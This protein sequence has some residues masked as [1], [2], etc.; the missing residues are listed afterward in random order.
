MLNIRKFLEGLRIIPRSSTAIDTKG[1]IEVLDS[2][3]KLRYHNGTSASAVVT[4]SHASQGADRLQNKDLDASS[5]KVVDPTDTTKKVGF[6]VAGATASTTTTLDFNQSAN[7][8]ISFPDAN[9]TL[10]T[11]SSTN[12]LSNKTLE[13]STSWFVDNADNT[14]AIK[15]DAAGSTG[16]STT[17]ASSQ[18]ANRTVTLPDATGTVVLSSGSQV[19]TDKLL[20]DTTTAVVDTGDNTK[21][22]KFDAG[23]TA[24]TSTT[25][26]ASQTADRTVSLPDASTT[27]V[28]TDTTQTLTNKTLTDST[29]FLQDD[30][31]NTKK[32]Q[33]QLSGITTGTTRTLTAPDV[34][35]TIVGTDATQ[36]LTNKTFTDSSTQFQ[37]DG[38]NTKQFR[39]QASGISTATTRTISVPDADITL[40]GTDTTQTLTNKTLTDSTTFLQDESDNSK[41]LQFQ[42]SGITTATTRTLTAP[43]ANTTIVG[44]DATQVITNKDIDGG[45]AANNR[46][47]TIPKDTKTNLDALTRK[48]GTV[49]YA[50]DTDKLYVDD[51]TTLNAVGSASGLSTNFLILDSSFLP[52]KSTNANAEESVGDWLAYAD[53]AAVSP[54]DMTGGSPNTTITRTTTSGEVLNG[55]ASFEITISS[56]ASRQGEGVYVVVNIPKEARGKLVKFTGNFLTSGAILADDI[57]QYAYDITNSLL[58]TPTEVNKVVGEYGN[59]VSYFNIPTNTT[60]IRLGFHIARTSTAALS[61]Y[62]DDMELVVS[63]PSYQTPVSDWVEYTP[64]FTGLGTVTGSSCFYRLV[65]D[66]LQV[67]ARFTVG[68]TT[69]TEARVSFPTG[70]TASSSKLP[71]TLALVGNLLHANAGSINTLAVYA[72][73]SVGYFTFGYRD[74]S[75][76]GFAK[77]NGSSTFVSS[78]VSGFFAEVPLDGVSGNVAVGFGEGAYISSILAAGTRVT[79]TPDVLGEYRT[80][81][82]SGASVITGTDSAPSTGPSAANGM[83][84]YANKNFGTA[85][86]SGEPGRW[87]IFVGKNKVPQLEFYSGTGKTGWVDVRILDV[88]TADIYGLYTAYDPNTG[89]VIIDGIT[90]SS[91][92]TGGRFAGI[93]FTG[94]GASAGAA[95]SCYFDIRVFDRAYVAGTAW[96][97]S[98][99]A[100]YQG[101]G[102]GSTNTTVRRFTS[103][104]S[105]IGQDI[106]Y[107]DSAT[108]GGSF[109]VNKTGWYSI[110]YSDNGSGTGDIGIT[111]NS[112][113]LTTG[114]SSITYAQ[115]KRS[116]A[117]FNGNTASCSWSGYLNAGDIIRAQFGGTMTN[118]A[119]QTIMTVNRI[120]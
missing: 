88:V 61:L 54:V 94:G 45:T 115:G 95:S 93:S 101:N 16:T 68:T 4:E 27:L 70:F 2:S 79:S 9:G 36:V 56:G 103:Q 43:D 20:D 107:A 92:N 17:I 116:N 23:G 33:F 65:G 8:T 112:T 76:A 106:T 51:G 83:L 49:V 110:A 52:N 118:S 10:I 81:H 53:A 6:D 86:T 32:L 48:E 1:E 67:K 29:T 34:N 7:R 108:L 3:S 89:V 78:T 28:G 91:N 35:T 69:A 113:A 37:D 30:S 44:T 58:I 96:I 26:A 90:S 85:G 97:N 63:Q 105:N 31:D 59:F 40:V 74:G 82:K 98:E 102:N 24:S 18:T 50:T 38:D 119:S 5:S 46:R 41:K 114:V 12:L 39:F 84:I 14:K 57:R 62:F 104:V 120:G 99:A 13:D 55:T 64:V 87:E 109:T 25:I 73:R 80:Y 60:S 19:L 117:S 15:F 71:S 100:V 42:L 72:E 75:Q 111:I 11:D 77:L 66:T 22:I 47:I 21:R